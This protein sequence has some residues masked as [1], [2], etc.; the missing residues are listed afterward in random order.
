M[1]EQ[2]VR[3]SFDIGVDTKNVVWSPH[4]HTQT[5]YDLSLQYNENESDE[6]KNKDDLTEACLVRS[7]IHLLGLFN[8]SCKVISASSITIGKSPSTETGE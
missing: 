1:S 7:I 2:I 8:D 4:I 5:K 6:M 3:V